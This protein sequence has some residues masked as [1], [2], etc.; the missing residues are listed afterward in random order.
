VLFLTGVLACAFCSCSPTKP[1]DNRDLVTIERVWQFLSVYSIYQDRVPADPF[2]GFTR[3]EQLTTVINDTLYSANEN[4]TEYYAPGMVPYDLLE[5]LGQASISAP[6]TL[7]TVAYQRLTNSTVYVWITGFGSYYNPADGQ[8]HSTASD[9]RHTPI[10]GLPN[11]I[12]DLR[13][14]PGGDIDVCTSSV[15]LFLP[16][17][18]PFIQTTFRKYDKTLKQGLTTEERWSSRSTGDVWEGK[19]IV[20]L[21]DSLSASAAE[22]FAAALRDG[23]GPQK[24]TL[25]GQRSYGKGIGQFVF[26]LNSGG[27][28]RITAFRFRRVGVPDSLADYHRKGI[29]P[30]TTVP[31]DRMMIPTAARILEGSAPTSMTWVPLPSGT[32]KTASGGGF[33]AV[34]EDDAF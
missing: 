9:L 10:T 27:A 32:P 12:I 19:N 1:L 22:I 21:M 20:I 5:E 18:I 26:L 8:I 7:G 23:L 3:P 34:R 4:Y 31:E 11:V 16:G 6:E 28:M 30:D 14:N 2:A 15:E 24:V 25:V 13:G 33:F 29:P 17:G